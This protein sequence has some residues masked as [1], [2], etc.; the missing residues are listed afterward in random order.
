[1]FKNHAVR[2]LSVYRSRY[3]LKARNLCIHLTL[4]PFLNILLHESCTLVV[5]TVN[6]YGVNLQRM[7]SIRYFT[8]GHVISEV[9]VRG[10]FIPR[11]N[12]LTKFLS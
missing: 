3:V 1:M 9:V 7:G 5:K 10:V 4:P 6:S 12:N 2:I 11:S 8:K